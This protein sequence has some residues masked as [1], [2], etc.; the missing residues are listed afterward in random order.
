MTPAARHGTHPHRRGAEECSHQ[1]ELLRTAWFLVGEAD[2]AEELTQQALVHMLPRQ[3][4]HIVNGAIV[5]LARSY[6]SER[7]IV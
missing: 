4:G 1:G 5:V 6:G 2:R 7:T 3:S